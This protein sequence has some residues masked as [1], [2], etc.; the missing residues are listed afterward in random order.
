MTMKTGY[1]YLPKKYILKDEMIFLT[2]TRLVSQ[3]EQELVNLSERVTSLRFLVGFVYCFVDNCLSLFVRPL[4]CRP[5]FHMRY[6]ITLWYFFL[7]LSFSLH[8]RM[9]F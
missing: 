3:V 8:K 9:T 4:Y 6:L 5:L 7:T 2:V 1:L